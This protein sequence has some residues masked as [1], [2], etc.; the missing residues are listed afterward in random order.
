MSDDNE[1]YSGEEWETLN[2][3][4]PKDIFRK[5]LWDFSIRLNR[6]T[7]EAKVNGDKPLKGV[8]K[9]WFLDRLNTTEIY[10]IP[11][12]SKDG[13]FYLPCGPFGLFRKK[14][15]LRKASGILVSYGTGNIVV[16]PQKTNPDKTLEE[17]YRGRKVV[18]YSNEEKFIRNLKNY[19]FKKVQ[20]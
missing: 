18:Q 17:M 14:L 7:G 20:L 10:E 9:K 1:N 11:T 19:G 13:K 16:Y 5:F 15:N 3:V 12:D 2:L 8:Q 6:E 4:L